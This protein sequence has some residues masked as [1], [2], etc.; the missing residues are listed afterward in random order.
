M[1][2][3]YLLLG[4]N[5]EPQKNIAA[6]LQHLRQVAELGSVSPAWQSPAIGSS[7]PDFLN[8]AAVVNTEMDASV[9]KFQVLRPIETLLGRER[10][11]DKFAPRTIDLDI[12][13]I[14]HEILEPDLWLRA[15][16][17]CP[18]SAL[19]PDLRHPG[20]QLTLREIAVDLASKTQIQK[21]GQLIYQ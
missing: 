20:T 13:I 17:A 5:I 11:S 19:L 15:H 16:I 6:A 2:A 1:R 7:G 4:S 21:V 14:D 9:L 10:T 12:L 8:L 18:L 3:V